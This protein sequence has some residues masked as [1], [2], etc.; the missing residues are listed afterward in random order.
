MLQDN[1]TNS[2]HHPS[3]WSIW[4]K[5]SRVDWKSDR[6]D[7]TIKMNELPC[8]INA[9][10]LDRQQSVV[11][12]PDELPLESSEML[13]A[14]KDLDASLPSWRSVAVEYR[15]QGKDAEFHSVLETIMGELEGDT[16]R[17]REVDGDDAFNEAA[18][19][20]YIS[21]AAEYTSVSS[22]TDAQKIVDL[23]RKA[24]KLDQL[25]PYTWI[26]K[27]FFEIR[28]GK[29][30]TKR[31]RAEDHFKNILIA[32]ER[33]NNSEFKYIGHMGFGITSYIKQNFAK[34]L[35]HFSQ[36]IMAYPNC[37]A[38]T[39]IAFALCAF[40]LEYYNRAMAAVEKVLEIDPY[41]PN[42][43]AVLGLLNLH[44]SQKEA[45]K[46]RE[47]R[48]L[49]FE[50]FT[51]ALQL[52]PT[53]TLAINHIANHYFHTWQVL[54][55]NVTFSSSDPRQIVFSD[56][57]SLSMRFHENDP[58]R[59]N[60]TF[61]TRIEQ[62]NDSDST[63]ILKDAFVENISAGIDSVEFKSYGQAKSLLDKAILTPC[64]NQMKAESHYLMGRLLHTNGTI[65]PALKDYLKALE[66]S[67]D[68]IP[69]IFGA[70][71]LTF[72]FNRFDEAEDFFH[73][74]IEKFPDD[75]DTLAHLY[76][77]RSHTK[78][79]IV[80]FDKLREV[81]IGFPYEADLWLIQG[82]LRSD[83][84]D[85]A[86]SLRCYE[87]AAV[88][89]TKQQ[90]GI[91]PTL[92]LNMSVLNHM[93]SN[94][95]TA[96]T[97][98]KKA[99]LNVMTSDS[100]DNDDKSNNCI[101]FRCHQNDVFYHWSDSICLISIDFSEE[102]PMFCAKTSHGQTFNAKE[103]F[104]IGEDISID[105]TILITITKFDE[106][107][108]SKFYASCLV[109][110]FLY[111]VCYGV[112]KPC[113]RKVS[114]KNFHLGTVLYCF[115]YARQLEDLGD[116]NA[117]MEIYFAILDMLPTYTDC[118]ARIG[119]ILWNRRN[120]SEAMK[121]MQCSLQGESNTSDDAYNRIGRFLIREFEGKSKENFEKSKSNYSLVSL[122]NIYR[123]NL[124]TK[125]EENLKL[126]YKYYHHI[127]SKDESN[128]YA[129]AGLGIVCAEKKISEIGKDIFSRI[130]ESGHGVPYEVYL[131]LGNIS[132]SQYRLVDAIHM[133]QGAIR[134]IKYLPHLARETSFLFDSLSAAYLQHGQFDNAVLSLIKSLHLYPIVVHNWFNIALA[135]E[136]NAVSILN[137][138]H[139]SI[140]DI[141]EA[142]DELKN[143]SVQFEF[144]SIDHPCLT[145]ESSSLRVGKS[146]AMDHKKFCDDN[147]E[148][149]QQHLSKAETDA[150][151][152]EMKRKL[153]EE[154]HKKI[155]REKL[156]EKENET[157]KEEQARLAIKEK[158]L[159]ASEKLE[160]LKG[161]WQSAEKAHSRSSKKS[162]GHAYDSD[163]SDEVDDEENKEKKR[164][165]DDE[166]P[167]EDEGNDVK[168]PKYDDEENFNEDNG[169]D[170][171][172]GIEGNS[173]AATD[174]EYESSVFGSNEEWNESDGKEAPVQKASR[175]IVDDD[176]DDE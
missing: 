56:K 38:S 119:Q 125:R 83:K 168:R 89:L 123:S 70:A 54:R 164:S 122:G 31:A 165:K 33:K 98:A 12:F 42:A 136:E 156:L 154:T 23:V 129:A 3:C 82:Q 113:Y 43:F 121:F 149:A 84:R 73:R 34:A 62:I 176:D 88:C 66:Y 167:D 4:H 124:G 22:T 138:P 78:S 50:F 85:F 79:T 16:E 24:E 69:A 140:V 146:K 53:C 45:S 114:N 44:A 130:R 60:G 14:L 13:Q 143:S 7:L 159:K 155:L 161:D 172:I 110:D 9:Q 108:P 132:V 100:K 160:S 152:D 59:I 63:L 133:Y 68:F 27:G 175:V 30:G 26:L 67:P 150:K 157:Q 97:Y 61:V 64:S 1:Q 76:L 96:I 111:E 47:Y 94:L 52:D 77:V 28:Q 112:D 106:T 118:Y 17:W 51:I 144:L 139:R 162:K 128:L 10:S 145:Q 90:N 142:M 170:G 148:K 116:E 101:E 104:F 137:Q 135:R 171:E 2:I 87:V 19:D 58:I 15:R 75:K 93:T 5:V 127:L 95:P 81:A 18:V 151:K 91:P 169:Q 153:Q 158:A 35:D 39:R 32:A 109:P 48:K 105:D 46:K 72:A 6:D 71:Q 102:I 8:S 174:N 65:Q 41:N 103:T 40:N 80:D 37:D 166:K 57:T 141:Q 115:N 134:S 92:Y 120:L 173:P 74:V 25:Q 117:A 49:S 29:D 126:A 36:A 55:E 86:S 99:L 11:I 21:R 20:I 131:N 147:F 163:S 107:D